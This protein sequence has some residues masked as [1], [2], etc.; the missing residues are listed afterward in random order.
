MAGSV[1][2]T[3]ATEIQGALNRGPDVV[4]LHGHESRVEGLG[5]LSLEEAVPKELF[6][7]V[8]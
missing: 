6:C 3:S 8:D 7:G 4:G 5:S 2:A 1:C